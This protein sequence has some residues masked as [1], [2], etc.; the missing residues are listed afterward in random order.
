MTDGKKQSGTPSSDKPDKLSASDNQ[1]GDAKS[2]SKQAQSND[3]EKTEKT[4][5]TD[6]KSDSEKKGGSEKSKNGS[7]SKKADGKQGEGKSSQSKSGA[8]SSGATGNPAKSDGKSSPNGDGQAN[9]TS[10]GGE[11]GSEGAALPPGDEANLEYNRQ[12]TE[13]V[14]QKL[15]KDLERGDA[16]PELLKELG[17]TPDEMKKFT[18]RVSKA[19]N[20]SKLPAETPEAKARQQQFQEMLKNLD[21]KKAGTQR[22]GEKEPKRDVNQVDSKRS[23]L[24]RDYRSAYEQW[25]KDLARQKPAASR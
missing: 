1:S 4:S 11:S 6:S 14:L 7:P 20:E 19:L 10:N 22:S 9:G 23:P 25:R 3:E 18:D 15:K 21:L 13:L 5:D 8:K 24:P 2:D 16:D 12:A 17:W